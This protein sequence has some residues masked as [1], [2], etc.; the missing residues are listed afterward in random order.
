M[1]QAIDLSKV[2][3]PSV[4]TQVDFEVIFSEQKA[5]LIALDP[6][7]EAT[8]ELE[9][10]P[11]T[12]LVQ[13]TAYRE[14]LLR[15]RMNESALSVMLAYST[16]TDLDNIGVNYNVERLLIKQGNPD[17][18][19][20]T[21]NIYESDADYRYRILLSLD[22]LSVAGPARAYIYHA[23]S[24]DGMVLDATADAPRFSLLT[25]SNDIKAQLPPGAIVL[26]VDYDAGLTNPRPG[27]VVVTVLSREG[28]GSPAFQLLAAVGE[29]LQSDAIRPLTDNPL[30]RQAQIIEYSVQATLYTF[31]GPDPEVAIQTAKANLAAYVKASHRLDR[32]VTL[33]GLYAALHV[34]GVQRVEL[35]APLADINCSPGQAAYCINSEI[36]YG[37]IAS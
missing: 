28:N 20:P 29:V 22:G 1:T 37:G 16:G 12:K 6:S 19:P 11:L 33:S 5:Q 26:N 27:D 23:L 25:V 24:A 13:L 36:N 34:G 15:Q 4:V 8:L 32:S 21:E 14:M 35:H 7:L 30:I 9:S 3:A 2:P 18:I 10:E 31:A 17:A